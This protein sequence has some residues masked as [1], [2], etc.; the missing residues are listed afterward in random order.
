MG[1]D[2]WTYTVDTLATFPEDEELVLIL[3]ADAAAGLPPGVRPEAVLGRARLAV[4]DA[5]G[6]SGSGRAAVG[7]SLGC[8]PRCSGSAGP[9]CGTGG[10][11]GSACVSW[12]PTPSWPTSSLWGCMPPPSR[13]RW[14]W[15]AGPLLTAGLATGGW[16]GA[17]DG[18]G[19]APPGCR[20]RGAVEGWATRLREVAAA[21]PEAEIEER[22]DLTGSRCAL[23]V[24]GRGP[25][26]SAFALLALSPEGLPTLTLLPPT[27]LG[28]VPGYGEFT[29]AEALVFEGPELAAL[30]IANELGLRIDQVLALPPGALAA[31]LPGAV[32]L[33]LPVPLFAAED[34]G[35]VQVLGPGSSSSPRPLSRCCWSPPG[36]GD[37]FEWLQRQGAAWRGILAVVAAD[38]AVA[39]RIAASPSGGDGGGRPATGGGDR[40]GP[41]AGGIPG[42]AGHRTG[43][44]LA[45]SAGAATEFVPARLG[46]LLLMAGERP[47]V[48]VLNGNGRIG[49]TRVVAEAVVRRG[50]RVVRTDN[51][52]R[53]DYAATLVVA[54]GEEAQEAARE[55]AGIVG[56]AAVYLEEAAPS[57]VVEVSII[58]GLD[59][60]AGEA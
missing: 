57:L 42:G 34:G 60:P 35:L 39:D 49:A 4:M 13:S 1:R 23:V 29:L 24:L 22:T 46:H 56:A 33:D 51:A 41:A 37:P 26:D 3:G 15:V 59:I 28:V 50:F 8:A 44:A 18:A 40:R 30:T 55:V 12:C 7:R 31:A 19:W 17:P 52:D 47:R 9:C 54:Q 32:T 6:G 25:G 2:G 5:P 38:P 48:E 16:R 10:G 14:W 11:P 53:F 36:P 20:T 43:E 27:L 45:L 58:V 21:V